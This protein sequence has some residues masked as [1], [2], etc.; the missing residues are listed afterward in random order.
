MSGRFSLSTAIHGSPGGFTLW[1]RPRCRIVKRIPLRLA[2][3]SI[4]L[5][6]PPHNDAA[7]YQDDKEPNQIFFASPAGEECNIYI[8]NGRLSSPAADT[9]KACES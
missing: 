9:P 7:A 6:A 1:T 4:V 8:P 5:L 3:V 2:H